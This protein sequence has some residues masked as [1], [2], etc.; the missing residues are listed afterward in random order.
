MCTSVEFNILSTSFSVHIFMALQSTSIRFKQA[1]GSCP[2]KKGDYI[3]YTSRIIELVT[4]IYLIL[5]DR[6]NTKVPVVIGNR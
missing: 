4:K 6:H 2:I 3:I 5:E 1:D